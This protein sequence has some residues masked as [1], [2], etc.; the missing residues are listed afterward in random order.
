MR[1]SRSS[2][3][4]PRRGKSKKSNNNRFASGP[5]KTW[6]REEVGDGPQRGARPVKKYRG[7]RNKTAEQLSSASDEVRLNKYLSNAGICSRREADDLIGAGLVSVNN[8]IVTSM[9]YKVKPK[10]VVKY[11]G[12][13]LKTDKMRYVLLN[14]PK[15][16]LTSMDDPKARKTVFELVGNACNERI[17]PVGQM[18]RG[19]TGVLLLTN[20]ADTAKKLTKGVNG[21]ANIYHIVLDKSLSKQQLDTIASGTKL[22]DGIVKVEEIHFTSDKNPR[23]LG[24][25][26]N[27]NKPRIVR[28]LFAHYG[29]E[30]EKLDRV[31]FAGLTKKK[32][33]RG[34][35]RHLDPKEVGF[36]KTR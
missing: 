17:Y 22:E 24:I 15:G 9:G 23:E 14:K 1:N 12:T 31:S 32:L 10:D 19:S 20:D 25:R 30:V 5:K 6:E 3:N 13:A 35:Y 4:G 34:E 26:I 11:N 33:N 29:F 28:R 8:K 7:V 18:E 36:L 27:A 16:F 21:A 2:N